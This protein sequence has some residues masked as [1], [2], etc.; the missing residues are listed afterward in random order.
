MV[1]DWKWSSSPD[2]SGMG[3]ILRR[4]SMSVSVITVRS[5]R[6]VLAIFVSVAVVPMIVVVM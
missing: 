3:R 5:G 2:E 1:E 6:M 4:A